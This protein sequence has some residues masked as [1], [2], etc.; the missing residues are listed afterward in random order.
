MNSSAIGAIHVRVFLRRFDY[1][2][3]IV[4][5]EPGRWPWLFWRWVS[6]ADGQ[7]WDGGAP[8]A[9]PGFAPEC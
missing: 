7:G 1:I 4:A 2:A 8:L 5:D 9:L 3:S 6:L